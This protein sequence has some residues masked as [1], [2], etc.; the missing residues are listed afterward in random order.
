SSPPGSTTSTSTTS[1]SKRPFPAR[2]HE[3]LPSTGRNPRDDGEWRAGRGRST[4]SRQLRPRFRCVGPFAGV[5][6]NPDDSIRINYFLFATSMLANLL[7]FFGAETALSL[8]GI[9]AFWV[10]VVRTLRGATRAREEAIRARKGGA[11]AGERE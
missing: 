8:V 5:Q 7:S 10:A 9:A 6:V 1:R 3:A 4:A 11:P 2:A